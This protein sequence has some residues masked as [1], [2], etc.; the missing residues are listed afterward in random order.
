ML[1][2]LST[3]TKPCAQT[4][5]SPSALSALVIL[6]LFYVLQLFF[7]IGL[8]YLL[9]TVNV[10]LRDL[11]QLIGVIVMVWMFTTPIFYPAE[12]VRLAGYGVLLEVNPMY[13][14][15]DSYRAVLLYG[16]WPDW[17][18][19]GAFALSALIAYALGSR[20]IALHKRTFPDML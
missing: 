13:W 15:I 18:M 1:V 11:Q 19:V 6:P 3:A 14:L 17:G 7:T 9:A 5:G 4:T 2:L 16:S 12:L 10:L 8:G 20:T